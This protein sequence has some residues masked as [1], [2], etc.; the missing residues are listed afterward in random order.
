MQQPTDAGVPDVPDAQP[1]DAN[2]RPESTA[3]HCC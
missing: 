3:F 2:T 1:P